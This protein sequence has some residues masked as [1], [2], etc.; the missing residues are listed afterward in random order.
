MAPKREKFSGFMLAVAKKVS[1]GFALACAKNVFL[2]PCPYILRHVIDSYI[3]REDA[4]AI[5]GSIG[6][7]MALVATYFLISLRANRIIVKHVCFVLFEVRCEIA[8]KLGRARC[9]DIE[10]SF[11]SDFNSLF[12][13]DIQKMEAALILFINNFTPAIF[14]SM[15][16]TALLT[17]I[18]WRVGVL[19]IAL[20]IGSMFTRITL[21]QALQRVQ[22]VENEH[23]LALARS[24]TQLTFGHKFLRAIGHYPEFA[25]ETIRLA[26]D[27]GESRSKL[28]FVL[29]K[30]LS[31]LIVGQQAI[32]IAVIGCGA[33]VVVRGSGSVGTVIAAVLML[34][35]ILGVL[36]Q[37]PEAMDKFVAASNG[38]R[39]VSRFLALNDEQPQGI[40]PA[41]DGP[42]EIHFREA[43]FRY[44]SNLER[45]I[46]SLTFK[47]NAGETIAVVG[48][49]GS[50]KTTLANLVMGLYSLEAGEITIDGLPLTEI[51]LKDLRRR[52]GFVPQ[53]PI[54]F[55]GTVASNIRLGSEKATDE[56]LIMV[57]KMASAHEFIE[58]L[59]GGYDYPVG[60][61]GS[62]LS[63]GQRQRIALARALLRKPSLLILDEAT[64]AL[65]EDNER[66]A[67]RTLLKLKGN[68]TIL[69]IAHR[70]STIRNADRV[71]HLSGGRL[72]DV[73]SPED[74]AVRLATK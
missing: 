11:S 64:S 20:I 45:T 37:L 71:L 54:V 48:E 34:P 36:M 72:C 1:P 55:D 63:G 30:L 29:Q 57:A 40:P 12:F 26:K 21:A 52:I 41:R 70:M 14:Y 7:C 16:M 59:P 44:R 58:A 22:R 61:R 28:A 5:F 27:L 17:I 62:R 13:S 49:S 25:A 68:A 60:E 67:E 15:L 4:A 2:V 18:E 19:V 23:Q 69:V 10:E 43:T 66:A 42:M 31:T 32:N 65:D 35:G 50:G 47:I 8:Q 6:L 38:Y 53:D 74:W 3:P 56:D 24:F 73:L 46:E 51:N 33:F 39:N 9:E